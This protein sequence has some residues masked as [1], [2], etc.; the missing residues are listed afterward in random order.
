[1][2]AVLAAGSGFSRGVTGMDQPRSPVTKVSEAPV[3]P[4]K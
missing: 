2:L 4:Q 1:M 3:L